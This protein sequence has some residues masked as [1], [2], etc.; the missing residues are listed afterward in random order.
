MIRLAGKALSCSLVIDRHFCHLRGVRKFDFRTNITSQSNAIACSFEDNEYP[1]MIVDDLN[2]CCGVIAF[3]FK[4]S[5]S[6]A[7]P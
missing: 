3:F 1:E 5:H 2:H 7:P 6:H 4:F